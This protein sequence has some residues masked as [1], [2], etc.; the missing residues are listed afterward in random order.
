[1]SLK[2]EEK[3][4]KVIDSSL[5]LEN[6]KRI[7]QIII[8]G[9]IT[10]IVFVYGEDKF[11]PESVAMKFSKEGFKIVHPE[12]DTEVEIPRE[13]P[14][15]APVQLRPDEVIARYSELSFDALRTRAVILPG[16]EKFIQ[17]GV[18]A[19]DMIDFLMG[20]GDNTPMPEKTIDGEVELGELEDEEGDFTDEN[21]TDKGAADTKSDAEDTTEAAESGTAAETTA[22]ANAAYTQGEVE[23][24]AEEQSDAASDAA[25]I[26]EYKEGA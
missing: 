23:K 18:E 11:L 3:V 12:N 5:T 7:H 4:L 1:M 25:T 2:T 26:T 17:E 14:F 6:S 21:V 13:I 22:D 20:F 16:G 24:A 9:E 8:N 19:Q 15:G 10:D